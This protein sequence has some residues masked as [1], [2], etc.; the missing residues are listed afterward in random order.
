MTQKFLEYPL[1]NG[2]IHNWLVVGPELFPLQN[3]PQN[4]S[5]LLEQKEQILRNVSE[6]SLRFTQTPVE[7]DSYKAGEKEYA[8]KYYRCADDNLVQSTAF[9][10][11]WHRLEAWAYT[12]IQSPEGMDV[13]LEIT[14]RQPTSIWLNGECVLSH[15]QN[16]EDWQLLVTQVSLLRL[17]DLFV[18]M[19]QV[20]RGDSSLQFGLKFSG[21]TNAEQAEQINIQVPTKA[22]FPHRYQHFERIL[23]HAYLEDIVQYRGDHFNLRWDEEIRDE[24]YFDFQVQDLKGAF[25]VSGKYQVDPKNPQDV[26]HNYR[27]YEKP[28][29]VTLMPTGKEYWEQGLRYS[30]RLP[31]HILD[32]KYSSSLYGSPFQRRQEALTDASKHENNLFAILA[33][34]ELGNWDQVLPGTILAAIDRVNQREIGC[35]VDLLGLLVLA[36][37][38]MEH[39]SFPTDLIAPITDSILRYDYASS[40]PESGFQDSE[41]ECTAV[42]LHTCETLAGQQFSS[43]TFHGSQKPGEFHQQHGTERVETWISQRGQ[44]GFMDWNSNSDWPGIFLALAQLASLAEDENLSELSTILL[45][46]MLFLLAVNSY[47]GSFSASHGRTSA[48]MLKSSQLEA[49]SGVTRM[50]WGVGVFNHHILGTVGLA[51]S[52]YE[53]PSF[54]YELATNIPDAGLQLEHHAVSTNHEINLVT[55]KTPDYMLSSAQDFQPGKPGKAEHLWQATFGT[56]AVVFVN[57]PGC[58][59]EDTAYQPGFWLGNGWLPRVAQWKDILVSVHQIPENDLMGF[60]HAY[61][62]LPAFDDFF[63]TDQWA[64]LQK[65]NGYLALFAA[66]G[67]KFIRKGPNAYRELRSSGLQNV[68]VCQLGRMATDG[69]FAE[70]R[71]KVLEIPLTSDSVGVRFI[72][73]RGDQISFGWQEPLLVNGVEQPLEFNKHIDGPF[74]Q[75]DFPASQMEINVGDFAMRLNF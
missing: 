10:P 38:F 32:N 52:D 55:Y 75:A 70:F 21:F 50:L 14:T 29:W 18:C 54:Y 9:T 2:Y 30:V 65:G 3:F 62:P 12:R 17:N 59:S 72:S 35:E 60:T 39:E 73:L 31:I 36:Y 19:Q 13:N 41:R 63:F 37:R 44:Y 27:L 68:W 11:T 40:D 7:L 6:I 58:S 28:F 25:Y 22:R 45:D 49:T 46:K 69:S 57:H 56:E 33:R 67:M 26:G 34:I 43:S 74:A 16:N 47:K 42:I 71:K 66:N 24:S 51:L 23:E 61:F 1:A 64:F 8:W 53:Y 48:K 5:N 20:S 15:K 4:N